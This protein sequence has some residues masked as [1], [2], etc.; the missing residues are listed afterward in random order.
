[1]TENKK[2]YLKTLGVAAFPVDN[3]NKMDLF[4][5]R[6]PNTKNV[7]INVS[8]G[9][10]IDVQIFLNE[11]TAIKFAGELMRAAKQNTLKTR[12]DPK[13]KK[14]KVKKSVKKNAKLDTAINKRPQQTESEADM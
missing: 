14:P 4:A 6:D 7:T 9:D 1:M 11:T 5:Y 13:P 10:N 3:M 12:A 2:Q 8:K